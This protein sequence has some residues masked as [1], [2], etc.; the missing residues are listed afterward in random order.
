MDQINTLD[1]NLKIRGKMAKTKKRKGDGQQ[2]NADFDLKI[3]RRAIHSSALARQGLSNARKLIPSMAYGRVVIALGRTQIYK[4][5]FAPAPFPRTLS[6]FTM[7]MRLA[8]LS[9]EEELLWSAAV[10]R[11]Y[12]SE[13]RAFVSAKRAFDLSLAV[14][15]PEEASAE[16]DRM[17]LRFGFSLWLLG[18]RI[19]VLQL[20]SGLKAQKDF[21]ESI[22]AVTGFSPQ[23]AWLSYYF[24]LRSEENVSYSTIA[25]ELSQLGHGELADYV[26]H[27]VLA[28]NPTQISDLRTPLNWDEPNPIIDRYETFVSV[29]QQYLARNRGRDL[30]ELEQALS[31]LVEVGDARINVMSNA[32]STIPDATHGF[33]QLEAADAY[34]IGRYD[35]A[36]SLGAESLELSA[37]SHALQGSFPNTP[38]GVTLKD[39]IVDGMRR[40]LLGSDEAVQARSNLRKIALTFAK[41]NYSAQILGFLEREHDHILVSEYSVIDRYV[42]LNGDLSNPW[43]ATVFSEIC[44][45]AKWIQVLGERHPHSP[46]LILRCALS[47]DNSTTPTLPSGLP[48]YRQRAYSGHLAY[49]RS[50]F[51]EAARQYRF[52]AEDKNQYVAITGRTYLFRALY[53]AKDYRQCLDLIVRSLL[54]GQMTP[55][56]FPLRELAKHCLEDEALLCEINLAILLHVLA[57]HV[58]PKWERE[59]S[60]VFENVLGEYGIERPSEIVDSQEESQHG[61]LV[62]FLRNICIPRI[63]DDST[64]FESVDEI[65]LER[66]AICQLLLKVDPDRSQ[67]YL[68]EIRVVTRDL[69]VAH[70][71]KKVQT[72]KIYVD[73]VGLRNAFNP[74]LTES[75]LRYKELLGSPIITYQARKLSKRMEEMIQSH[76][77]LEFRDLKLPASELEGLLKT[78]FY[79]VVEQFAFNPAYGLDTHLSTTIRHG[80]FEGHLRGPLAT[81]GLLC[82][83]RD[84]QYFVPENTVRRLNGIEPEDSQH[85]KNLLTRFTIRV[86]DM[87][88]VYLD[89][90]LRVRVAGGSIDAL[91]DLS[92]GVESLDDIGAAIVSTT[93]TE[94]LGNRLVEHCWAL[95]DLSME[96]I[97]SELK[98][99][100]VRQID[101]AFTALTNGLEENIQREHI[102]PLLDAIVR[103]KTAF[104][105]SVEDVAEWFR[106][107]TDFIR[108][109]FEFEVAVHVA[110]KQIA[111]CYVDFPLRAAL[112]LNVLPKLPGEMLDGLCEILFILLQ[113]VI[114]HSGF[115]EQPLTAIIHASL[116]GER[117]VIRVTNPLY[118]D[119]DTNE[120]RNLATSAESRYERDS[121]MKLARVE[122]GSGLSKVWRIAEFDLRRQHSVAL[123]VSSGGGFVATIT[124][125]NVETVS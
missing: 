29:A 68:A 3:F 38:G 53:A 51:F 121:A 76:G 18:H 61:Q 108:D 60:D 103:A 59:L 14:G 105:A 23:A 98:I 21:L 125:D 37:R 5:V 124:I 45:H 33:R 101:L 34:T 104:H 95:I 117:L 63:L 120:L 58:H 93:S 88:A 55:T 92:T 123:Q 78:M 20:Q 42:A 28:F 36:I 66:I 17:E 40:S 97:R 114:L 67:D 39:K 26:Y 122:G 72:S 24:S 75:L 43:N 56:L 70:L 73:E 7:R 16:L 2:V 50:N 35:D 112:D 115:T 109:P 96:N 94:I 102:V 77:L 30:R 47:S 82:R 119:I 13:L 80:A 46:A 100:F 4:K 41:H 110:L 86:E 9:L 89:K 6:Q 44:L 84:K 10:L 118:P 1:T 48:M 79:D 71:L 49:K 52:C 113:N 81:E 107:P 111:N 85:I 22:F 11:L 31:C 99:S 65:E 64:A 69:N 32:L 12:V 54:A 57:K 106:R 87:I 15:T 27:H 74:T 19:Q 91:F 62:Y 90:R 83:K 25:G 8:E 116:L